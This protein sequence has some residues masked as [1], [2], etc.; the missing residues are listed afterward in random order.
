ML[1]KSRTAALIAFGFYLLNIIY[2]VWQMMEQGNVSGLGLL[3]NFAVLG[4]I[5]AGVEG[6]HS[7]HRRHESLKAS[8]LADDSPAAIAVG[9]IFE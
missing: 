1:K 6:I 4:G 8:G 5:G 9:K 2:A 7:Y 3:V